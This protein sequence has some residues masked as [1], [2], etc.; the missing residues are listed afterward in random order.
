MTESAT[1]TTTSVST[2][3]RATGYVDAAGGNRPVRGLAS[4]VTSSRQTP[5]KAAVTSPEQRAELRSQWVKAKRAATAIATALEH[6]PSASFGPACDLTNALDGMWKLRK[7]LDDDNW[8]GI[9]DRLQTTLRELGG[10][11][12]AF[13]TSVQ[14]RKLEEFVHQLL[15]LSEKTERDLFEAVRLMDEI[16]VPPFVD[17]KALAEVKD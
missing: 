6:D 9:L 1:S 13:L 10:D 12:V 17:F 11:G 2:T 5:S 14:G 4:V 8:T 15:S 16:G 3:L 7:H